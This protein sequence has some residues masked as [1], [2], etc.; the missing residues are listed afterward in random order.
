M[1]DLALGFFF[2]VLGTILGSFLNALIYRLSSKKGWKSLLTERSACPS[3]GKPI[4]WHDNV[5]IVS[6]LI[7]RGRCRDCKAPISPGYPMIELT[8]GLL[9]VSVY[10]LFR[11]AGWITVFSYLFFSLVLLAVAVID[12][13]TYEIP[14]GLSVGSTLLGL[15]LSFFRS[16]ITPL[17]SFAAAA[18]GVLIVAAII[19]IY[20][21]LRGLEALGW[22]D[23]KLLAAVGA[24]EGFTGVYCALLVGSLSALLF[25]LPV[26]VKNK[27][28]TFTVPFAPFLALG[29]L[30]G[31]ACRAAGANFIF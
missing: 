13:K 1:T 2:F 12:W 30:F 19:W 22:G 29:A 23:A 24:F 26:I 25:F 20:K 18:G 11:D 15:L 7:L 28:L 21:K 14:D 17:E 4:R 9:A 10:L 27:T 31:M 6:Y 8:S 5:P 3:C 16:D